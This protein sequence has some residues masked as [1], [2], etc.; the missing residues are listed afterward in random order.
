MKFI[1]AVLVVFFLVG[2]D[3]TTSM[4]YLQKDAF[5]EQSIAH[6]QKGDLISSSETKAIIS[7][8]YLNR[9]KP[10]KYKVNENFF[11]AVYIKDDFKS[12]KKYGLKNP[13]YHLKLNG[14]KPLVI[15]ELDKDATLRKQMPLV[16]KWN[17]YYQVVFKNTDLIAKEKEMAYVKAL[18][19]Y[20]EVIRDNEDA[21]ITKPEKY[22][23]TKLVLTFENDRFGK[24][25]LNFEKV[26]QE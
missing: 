6:L 23:P 26:L 18:K 4:A 12:K 3:R 5:Y 24:A 2:C 16:N 17:K 14:E 19:E 10:E 20:E 8:V 21:K 1:F 25:S 9:V 13:L 15:T 7:A 11:V 22:S